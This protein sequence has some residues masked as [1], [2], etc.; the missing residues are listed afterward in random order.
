[1]FTMRG[2]QIERPIAKSAKEMICVFSKDYLNSKVF[3][4]DCRRFMSRICYIQKIVKEYFINSKIRFDLVKAYCKE[5]K[6][7]IVMKMTKGKNKKL[8]LQ[9]GKLT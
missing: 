2:N 5:Q 3:L 6:G 4:Y 1:M 8:S 9:I 7:I